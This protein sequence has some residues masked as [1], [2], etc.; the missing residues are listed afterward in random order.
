MEDYITRTHKIHISKNSKQ[1]KHAYKILDDA[2]FKSKN[3]YNRALYTERQYFFKTNRTLSYSDLY[4][5]LKEEDSFKQLNSLKSGLSQQTLKLTAQSMTAFTKATKVYNN[6]PSKFTGMPELPKYL[7]KSTGR[8]IL[9]FTY[10]LFRVTNNKLLLTLNNN[11]LEFNIPSYLNGIVKQTQSKQTFTLEDLDQKQPDLTLNQ[12]R[13]IPKHLSYDLELVYTRKINKPE[14]TNTNNNPASI[15]LGVN[16]FITLVYL[17]PNIDPVIYSGKYLKSYNKN[18]NKKLAKLQSK[19]DT[20]ENN[21]QPNLNTLM[22]QREQLYQKRNQYFNTNLHQISNLI[23]RDLIKNNVTQLIIG[24]NKQW[25]TESKL[26]KKVNQT[27]VQI[28]YFKL[29]QILKYKANELGITVFETEEKHT[30]GASFLDQEQPTKQNYNKSRRIHR[31]LFR[32]ATNQLINADVNAAYQ[33]TK[34]IY[35][36]LN[37]IQPDIF[38]YQHPKTVILPKT[39]KQVA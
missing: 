30:S 32:S 6:N 38:R 31:G 34:K 20:A 19:I 1:Y 16:N 4:K 35:P 5:I 13:I 37:T 12:V 21:N 25:K 15:D 39:F 9:D 10:T 2:C 27:F 33:I 17:Q 28:P 14:H 3:L 18:F 23:I 22:N 26:S 29:I 11:T 8:Q 7:R 36:Q 24:Y